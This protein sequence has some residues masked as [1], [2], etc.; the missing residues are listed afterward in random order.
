MPAPDWRCTAWVSGCRASSKSN[1]RGVA[2]VWMPVVR[3]PWRC[4]K[5]LQCLRFRMLAEARSIAFRLAGMMRS[6]WLGC[7]FRAIE[8]S[9]TGEM[10]SSKHQLFVRQNR[11]GHDVPWPGAAPRKN[12]HSHT[13]TR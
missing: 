12:P 5:E 13:E 6:K 4:R 11:S 8:A 2:C 3:S 10:K 9:V 1:V 7:L